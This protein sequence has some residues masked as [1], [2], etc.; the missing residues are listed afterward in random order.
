MKGVIILPKYLESFWTPKPGPKG[1][2]FDDI[3]SENVHIF[4]AMKKTF[5]FDLKFA[6]EVNVNNGVDV[7]LMFGV[8]YHNRPE[9]IPGLLDLNKSIKLIMWPG[10]L[11]CYNNKVCLANKIKVFERCDLIIP[12]MYEY[13]VEIYPQFVSKCKFVPKFFAP[14]ERYT[15][16]LFNDNP[17]TK[18]LLSGSLNKD[19]YPFRFFIV[20]KRSTYVDYEPPRHVGAEYAKLLHSYFCCVT[21]SSIFNYVL[22]KY[23]EIPATGS[24]LLANETKDSKR[25][26]FIPYKHYV[27][28]TKDDVFI[29]IKECIN[30]PNDY[31]NIR[32][33]GMNFVRENHSIVNR[34]ELLRKIFEEII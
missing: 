31:T 16:F 6:D 8:P 7:V 22:A 5:G 10:D 29:K 12:F 30:N 13:F 32:K 24:L 27:P 2:N 15:K 17:I 25:I 14:H 19:V 18:C 20:D 34:I 1:S 9:L 33:E 4:Y 11:Q 23:F 28:I 3:V 21:S 26:G